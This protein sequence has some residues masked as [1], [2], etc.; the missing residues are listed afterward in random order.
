M[1]TF[2]QT[3]GRIVGR[4]VYDGSSGAGKSTNLRALSLL[5]PSPG[6][7]LSPA[8][9]DLAVLCDFQEL[10]AGRVGDFPVLCQV[11]GCP[12]H[13]ALLPRREVL[14]ASAD[15]VVLVC[16]PSM[17]SLVEI[18]GRIASLRRCA[19]T[20]GRPLVLVVQANKQDRS[21]SLTAEELA[22]FLDLPEVPVIAAVASAGSGVVDTY[23][24]AVRALGRTLG[25]T[26]GGEVT[27]LP[28]GAPETRE[29]LWRRLARVPLVVRDAAELALDDLVAAARASDART[30]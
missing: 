9:T 28:V 29:A 27:R 10:A 25:G 21:T 22:H 6:D 1:A 23:L 24:A 11:L 19:E 30:R 12:S 2:D 13:P 8:P 7:A 3:R 5:L 20:H 26:A 17:G 4:I 18:Q 14:V 16:E 15:V